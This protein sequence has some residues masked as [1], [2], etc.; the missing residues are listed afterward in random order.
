MSPEQQTDTLVLGPMMRHVDTDSATVWVETSRACEVVVEAG[1]VTA[2]ARTFGAHGHHYA[3]VEVEG[4][5]A[6]AVGALAHESG[7]VL[8]A[9]TALTRSLEEAYVAMT[10]D[11]VEYSTPA[12]RLEGASR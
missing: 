1:S 9:L 11:S 7:A 8:H 4:L 10:A 12:P 5:E 3:L 2:S 6:P